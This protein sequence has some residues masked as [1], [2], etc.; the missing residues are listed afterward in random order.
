MKWSRELRIAR[1]S[2]RT[3]LKAAS[4]MGAAKVTG[5]FKPPQFSVP[6]SLAP[7]LEVAEFGSNPGRLRMLVHVPP[8]PVRDAPLIVLLHGCGQNAAS[9]AADAGW[10]RLADR[11]A[12]PLVLPVQSEDNN[13][14][15][16]FNWFRPAHAARG[17]G[18][19]LSIRQMVS[20][21]VQRFGSDSQRVFIAGLSAGGA[22]AAALLA[23]YP[24][25]FAAGAVCAGLPVGAASSVSEALRRM[26]EAG[27]P[28]SPDAWADQAR[29]AAPHGYRG[30]WP[31]LSIWHGAAD[32]VVDPEN[33]RL[34][35]TQWA[36]LHGLDATAAESR[37]LGGTRHEQWDVTQASGDS[38]FSHREIGKAAVELWTL[39]ALG[40]DWPPGAVEHIVRFW[41][42]APG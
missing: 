12:I 2:M 5:P 40:H 1:R 41:D 32:R 6:G 26:A 21:A 37:L 8:S 28:R 22:M 13:Q 34:L 14:S 20:S 4:A 29:R 3:A 30:P 24:E 35:A 39:D 38:A 11:L 17:G 31:R 25:V 16:C 33:A 42:I 7:A 15:R 9:F 18:E 27:P 36:G 10:I 23:A 19:A